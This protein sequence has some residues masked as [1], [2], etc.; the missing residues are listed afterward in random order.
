MRKKQE[1]KKGI[2]ILRMKGDKIS[3]LQ[4][5]VL[6]NGHNESLVFATYVASVPEEDKDETV[7]Y[8]CRD[9]ARF[10]AGRLSLEEL[11]PD[12]DRYPVTVDRPE[13][14][15][16][17]SVSVREFEILKRKVAQLEGFVE[18]LLKNAANVPN[19]RNCRIRT[20]RTISARKMLQSL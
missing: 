16:R 3:L 13:P 15:E 8:A 20:V 1:I 17:Q 2:T 6:E 11:I 4:A 14:K 12:V 7:F 5:E 18:D 19:T 10:A 9:A